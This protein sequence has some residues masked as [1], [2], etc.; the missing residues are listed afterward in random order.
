[1]IPV[2][3]IPPV[4]NG[5]APMRSDRM[6]D[7]GPAMRIPSVS[8]QH[9]DAGPQRGVLEAVAVLGQPDALQPDDQHEHQPAAGAR[10][11]EARQAC[12]R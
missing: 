2:P 9:V 7:R 8:G 4:E 6:P 5:R 10:G 1:M 11:E 12:R 3:I